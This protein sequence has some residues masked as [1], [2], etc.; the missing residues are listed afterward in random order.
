MKETTDQAASPHS[1]EKLWNRRDHGSYLQTCE[2]RE[3]D[4]GKPRINTVLNQPDYCFRLE[5][6]SILDMGPIS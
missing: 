3:F 1:L 5:I 6:S 4:W 2:R